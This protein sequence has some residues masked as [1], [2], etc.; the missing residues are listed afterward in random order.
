M[1]ESSRAVPSCEIVKAT[2]EKTTGSDGVR[3]SKF[4][5]KLSET[6]TKGEFPAVNKK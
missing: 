4:Q 1:T 5:A 3:V 2:L 6:K